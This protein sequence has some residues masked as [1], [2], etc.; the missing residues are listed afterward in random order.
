MLLELR[1]HGNLV[2]TPLV[3][4]KCFWQAYAHIRWLLD[5]SMSDNPGLRLDT[6]LPP[7]AVGMFTIMEQQAHPD[8]ISMG[9]NEMLLSKEHDVNEE[10]ILQK[11][12]VFR[13]QLHL[14]AAKDD[15]ISAFVNAFSQDQQCMPSILDFVP[16]H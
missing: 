12:Q 14:L 15:R 11:E 1:Q 7:P 6:S 2:S 3:L 16:S 10:S 5:R 13:K 9:A 4:T 8:T